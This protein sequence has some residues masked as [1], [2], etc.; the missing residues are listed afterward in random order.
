MPLVNG[1]PTAPSTRWSTFAPQQA[2]ELITTYNLDEK[3]ALSSPPGQDIAWAERGTMV[4]LSGGGILKFPTVLPQSLDFTPFEAGKRAYKSFDAAVKSV[5][6]APY[7][8]NFAIPMIWDQQGNGYKLMSVQDG[9]LVDFLGISG[10]GAYYAQAGRMKK[11]MLIADLFYTSM[12]TAAGW[13]VTPSKFTYPQPNNSGGIALFTDGTGAEGSGGA[14]HY[15]NPTQA[16]SGR[17]TN[18]FTAY[19]SFKSNYARSLVQMTL[20]PHALY[21]NV[22]SG[23]RVTDTIGPTW[24]RTKFWEMAV[25][26]LVLQAETVGGNGVA[27]A[28]TNPYAFAKTMGLT[29]ENFIGAAFGPR[30]FWIAPH[31]DNHPYAVANPNTHGTGQPAEMWI[32]ISAG[33][34]P[35]TGKPRPTW[36]KGACSSKEFVPTFFFYGPGDPRAESERRMRFEG[37]LDG[38]F[39]PGAPSEV[40]AFF[41]V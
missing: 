29:E 17:F 1:L 38:A 21:Q 19:G 11:A 39:E 10:V 23:A 28:V 12:Y 13:A 22:T 6:A 27:A 14:S 33:L 2:L 40:Q 4:G 36:A 25:Q 34:D 5:Y 18:L 41:E 3:D 26:D 37:N 9:N 24:M 31:L 16:S 20:T 15:A 7:D 32:N 8:L 30:R 35:M